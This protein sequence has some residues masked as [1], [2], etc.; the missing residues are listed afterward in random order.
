MDRDCEFVLRSERPLRPRFPPVVPIPAIERDHSICSGSLH[1]LAGTLHFNRHYAIQSCVRR[2]TLAK[3]AQIRVV[4]VKKRV[5]FCVFFAV[6]TQLSRQVASFIRRRT[7][8]SR[9]PETDRNPF[10]FNS[11]VHPAQRNVSRGTYQERLVQREMPFPVL[12]FFIHLRAP[13]ARLP[14]NARMTAAFPL[15]MLFLC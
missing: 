7:K 2:K 11:M 5:R 12:V 4:S 13:P 14:P 6:F 1:S 9:L 15:P 3:I 10:C 8:C